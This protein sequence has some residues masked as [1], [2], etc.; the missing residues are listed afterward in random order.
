MISQTT[1][2][3]IRIGPISGPRTQAGLKTQAFNPQP[4]FQGQQMA[5]NATIRR[6]QQQLEREEQRLNFLKEQTAQFKDLVG[7]NGK[8]EL[9]QGSGIEVDPFTSKGLNAL[10]KGQQYQ[11]ELQ[12]KIY[13]E[14]AKATDGSGKLDQ[15]GA[16]R[17]ID[18]IQR[19]YNQKMLNDPDIL[20]TTKIY[21]DRQEF[22]SNIDAAEKSGKFVDPVA[23]RNAMES[24]NGYLDDQTG[25]LTYDKSVF[26]LEGMSYNKKEMD[27]T[28]DKLIMDAVGETDFAEVVSAASKG[29]GY[30]ES[31]GLLSQKGTV[32]NERKKALEILRNRLEKDPRMS[33]Y[34]KAYHNMDANDFFET[35]IDDLLNEDDKQK[36]VKQVTGVE[37]VNATRRQREKDSAAQK[38]KETTT[39]YGIEGTGVQ[40]KYFRSIVK[41]MVDRDPQFRATRRQLQDATDF[42]E[43]LND[44]DDRAL[45]SENIRIDGQGRVVVREINEDGSVGEVI[46]PFGSAEQNPDYIR[47]ARGSGN[48]NI[49]G[50]KS[51]VGLPTGLL[52]EGSG[53]IPPMNQRPAGRTNAGWYSNNPLNIKAS[54]KDASGKGLALHGSLDQ[55]GGGLYHIVFPSVE[56]GLKYGGNWIIDKVKGGKS[57]WASP[58]MSLYEFYAGGDNPEGKS[59]FASSG[60]AAKTKVIADALGVDMNTS[61]GDIIDTFTPEEIAIAFTAMEN[62]QMYKAFTS[63]TGGV[64]QDPNVGVQ[65]EDGEQSQDPVSEKTIATPESPHVKLDGTLTTDQKVFTQEVEKYL[66]D[67]RKIDDLIQAKSLSPATVKKLDDYKK[68]KIALAEAPRS[69][70][71]EYRDALSNVVT[72]LDD[73]EIYRGYVEQTLNDD[74]KTAAFENKMTSQ[75]EKLEKG[76]SFQYDIE[77]RESKSGM[78]GRSAPSGDLKSTTLV[79]GHDDEGLFAEFNVGLGDKTVEAG[80]MATLV[81]RIRNKAPFM[82][83]PSDIIDLAF[84][85]KLKK[86]SPSST[87]P[88]SETKVELNP[89]DI[90]NSVVSKVTETMTGGTFTKQMAIDYITGKNTDGAIDDVLSGLSDADIATVKKEVLGSRAQQGFDSL[91][92]K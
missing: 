28:A 50:F 53:I 13:A 78:G 63:G 49:E 5:I 54:Q 81:K 6:D 85:A 36:I 68:A 59:R 60:N 14:M 51:H 41:D 89:D 16:A 42:I 48:I 79:I 92:P 72:I 31:D 90:V 35:R 45:T 65:V 55:E 8:A 23:K 18:L 66:G 80:D 33:S 1:P 27:A 87:E 11:A 69:K 77:Y 91:K 64:D 84:D 34:I 70:K 25:E 2:A 62:G 44:S 38:R 71:Q 73:P 24:V 21:R 22:L 26:N 52:S 83:Y 74:E 40:D 37:S 88:I 17:N 67:D 15:V 61:M 19:D 75:L 4:L 9:I 47:N 30:Q 56:E 43:M 29:A 76:G 32:Q 57:K 10:N 7:K 58:E 12:Q 86:V 82:E 20:E 39:N 3:G 46:K